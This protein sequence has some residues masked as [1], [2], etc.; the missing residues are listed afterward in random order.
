MSLASIGTAAVGMRTAVIAVVVGS[1]RSSEEEI[2]VGAAL[3]H[4]DT[5]ETAVRAVLDALNR[6]LATL[7]Q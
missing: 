3:S 5:S 6:R 4:G 2:V 1:L 7:N